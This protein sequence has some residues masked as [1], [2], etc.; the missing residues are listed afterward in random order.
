MGI[1]A[2]NPDEAAQLLFGAMYGGRT[3]VPLNLTSSAAERGALAERAGVATVLTTVDTVV[4][5]DGSAPVAPADDALLIYTSGTTGRSKGVVMTHANLVAC[6][7][8]TAESHQLEPT[9]RFLCV[10]PLWHR[11]SIDMLLG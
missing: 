8:S 5:G 6:A 2:E 3:A 7:H 9:D 4:A 11:N 10:L 1:A